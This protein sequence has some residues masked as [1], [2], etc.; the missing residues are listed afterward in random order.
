MDDVTGKEGSPG[1]EEGCQSTPSS[2][3]CG[4]AGSRGGLQTETL[5]RSQWFPKKTDGGRSGA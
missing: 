3:G 2:P 4:Q 1:Q 5:L